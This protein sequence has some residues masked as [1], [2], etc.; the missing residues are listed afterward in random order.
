MNKTDRNIEVDRFKKYSLVFNN[1]FI[2]LAIYIHRYGY[3][4]SLFSYKN[5][6]LKFD[7]RFCN[8]IPRNYLVMTIKRSTFTSLTKKAINIRNNSVNFSERKSSS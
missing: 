7:Y 2:I 5:N 8:K 6:L 3:R 4:V 1:I